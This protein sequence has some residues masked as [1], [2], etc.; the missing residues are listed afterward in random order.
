MSVRL[1]WCVSGHVFAFAH[2]PSITK[3]SDSLRIA[4]IGATLIRYGA[5]FLNWTKSRGAEDRANYAT[6][7]RRRQGR[8]ESGPSLISGKPK[9]KADAHARRRYLRPIPA[10]LVAIAASFIAAPASAQLISI[11]ATLLD[12]DA[13]VTVNAGRLTLIEGRLVDIDANLSAVIAA[14][15]D[16]DA[17]ISLLDNALANTNL[18]IDANV[19]AIADLDVRVGGVEID[20]AAAV[21]RN[22]EQDVVLADHENRIDANGRAIAGLDGRV[23][24]LEVDVA[25]GIAKDVEQDA[26]LADHSTRI[27]NAQATAALALD[28]S[29][30]LRAD[31]EAGRVGL[32]RQDAATGTISVGAQTGG[33]VVSLAGTDGDRRLTGIADGVAS[34]DAASVGQAERLALATLDAARGY[35]DQSVA[36]MFDT[37]MAATR[38]L[39]AENNRMLRAD[40]NALAANGSALSGLPQSFLPGKGMA[41]AAIGGHGGEV[42]F[43][44]GVSKAT[45]SDRPTVFRAGAAMD[46]RRGEVSYNA[47]VGFHF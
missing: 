14:Q 26:R 44:L 4:S 38:T 27:D 20:V 24:R 18:R 13:R 19:Q 37:S 46:T 7:D 45:E 8:A 5:V 28:H 3:G 1:R 10:S 36:A 25:A 21:E 40:M 41:G 2:F 34:N 9:L 23:G 12:I 32:V 39:M 22:R 35:T 15:V 17:R 11:D 6:D 31:V 42:A 16:A 29:T 30:T 33:S 47:G 43:A